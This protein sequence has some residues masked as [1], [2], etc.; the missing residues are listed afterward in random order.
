MKFK[1]GHYV[2]K[3]GHPDLHEVTREGI[4]VNGQDN[5]YYIKC[6][7]GLKMDIRKGKD[8]T[9]ATQQ[10]IDE[11]NEIVKQRK[12]KDRRENQI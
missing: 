4:M 8:L 2:F 9:L 1:V 7:W 12:E 11:W 10:Q 5:I 3:T 6:L